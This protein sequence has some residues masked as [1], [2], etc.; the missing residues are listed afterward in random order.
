MNRDRDFDQTLKR[1]L[2]DGA[3]RAPERYVWAALDEVDRTRQPGAWA[4]LLEG[5]LMK[6][7]PA[8]P[9]LG[10]AAVLLVAI[11]AYQFLGGNVGGPPEPTPTPRAYTAEELPTIVA[12]RDSR[13][14]GMIV[15]GTTLGVA[16]LVT[17]LHPDGPEFDRSTMV[18]AL[19][20]N[21]NTT[22]LG[23]FVSWGVVFDTVSSAQAA[24]DVLIATHTSDG[25]GME[26]WDSID[27]L[28]EESASYE[29]AAYGF[30]T[31]RVHLWRIGNLLLA[32][33][34]VGDVAI[35]DA[36]AD[37]L[38]TLAVMMNDSAE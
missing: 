16:A 14:E 2:D 19:M 1:W 9:I 5:T 21:L 6:L 32:A 35:G 12:V 36:N 24:Y 28:G 25:W 17:P 23:G 11:A 15:D 13:P 4:A 38:R 30:D 7:K 34:A 29:G 26:A 33:V 10:V 18:D 27:G 20:T 3:D 37:Q 8:V 22:D 31:A